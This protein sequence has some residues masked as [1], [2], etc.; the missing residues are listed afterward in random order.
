MNLLHTVPNGTGKEA[1]HYLFYRYRMLWEDD[2]SNSLEE[3]LKAA[4][5]Y[6][7]KEM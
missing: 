6:L 2:G 3:A 5:N 7:A 4:E 1:A